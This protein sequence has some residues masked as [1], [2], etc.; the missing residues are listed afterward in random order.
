MK[1]MARHEV[2]VVLPVA[3]VAGFGGVEA[4]AVGP[5]LSHSAVFRVGEMPVRKM[6]NGGESWDVVHGVLATGEAVSVH[7]SQQPVGAVPNPAHVIQHTEFIVVLDG[8]V[9]FLHD[10]KSEKVGPGGVIYVALETRHQLKNVGDGPAKYVV[11]AIG[12]DVKK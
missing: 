8:T 1:N 4:R 3:E 6:A 5:T 2:C 10:E 11:V 12:G 7:E 9:E